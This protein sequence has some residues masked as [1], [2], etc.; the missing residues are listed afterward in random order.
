M[1]IRVDDNYAINKT[2]NISNFQQKHVGISTNFQNTCL[3]VN[4]F[5]GRLKE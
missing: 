1:T 3:T 5:D 2:I 4:Q